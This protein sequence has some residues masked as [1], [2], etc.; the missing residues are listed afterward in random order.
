[1]END[2]IL[3]SRKSCKETVK[4]LK[5]LQFVLGGTEIVIKPEGYTY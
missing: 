2:N 3:V 1:M 4:V 5:N